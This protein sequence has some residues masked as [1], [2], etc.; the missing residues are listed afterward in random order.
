MEHGEVSPSCDDIVSESLFII[1]APR[2]ENQPHHQRTH[3]YR[4]EHQLWGKQQQSKRIGRLDTLPEKISFDPTRK[5]P[6][7][8]LSPARLPIWREEVDISRATQVVNTST[9]PLAVVPLH[10]LLLKGL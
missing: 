9:F 2:E 4:C 7:S 8:P 1:I 5:S 10:S 6:T 3:R